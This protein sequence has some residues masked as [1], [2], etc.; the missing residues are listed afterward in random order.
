MQKEKIVAKK[1]LIR[2]ILFVERKILIL[3]YLL[4]L[5]HG[6]IHFFGFLV[7]WK[8]I[9]GFEDL[10]YKTT[11]FSEML[12]IGDVGIRIFGII[13]LLTAVGYII[14]VIGL[15]VQKYDGVRKSLPYVTVISLFITVL[16]FT[17]A[18]T[19]VMFNVIVLA[20]LIIKRQ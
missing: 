2:R 15:I 17:V 13:W 19:G 6:L 18:Y 16:D 12:D 10:P 14:A 11:V 4:I 5:I 20:G 1:E 7:Y 3:A 8:I 9:E